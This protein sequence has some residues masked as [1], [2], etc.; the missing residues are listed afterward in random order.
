MFMWCLKFLYQI[1]F[2]FFWKPIQKFVSHLY[3]VSEVSL[4]NCFYL[5]PV[6]MV[7]LFLMLIYVMQELKIEKAM[8]STFCFRGAF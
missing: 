1:A 3:V 4:L 5:E 6:R 7:F 2:F 8:I